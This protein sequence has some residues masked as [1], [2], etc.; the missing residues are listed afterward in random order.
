ML[1]IIRDSN[2][3]IQ[4]TFKFP[5]QI[6]ARHTARARTHTHTHTHTLT[7]MNFTHIKLKEF[8]DSFALSTYHSNK[9]PTVNICMYTHIHTMLIRNVYS[10]V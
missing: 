7:H 6:D 3:K 1:Q 9:Q 10:Y 8:L 5:K 2:K 4:P